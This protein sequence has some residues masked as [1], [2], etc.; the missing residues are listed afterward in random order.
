MTS[1]QGSGPSLICGSPAINPSAGGIS[2]MTGC[3]VRLF[4]SNPGPGF[5]NRS[6]EEGGSFAVQIEKKASIH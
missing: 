4:I 5:I 6:G 3:M 2:A 1:A